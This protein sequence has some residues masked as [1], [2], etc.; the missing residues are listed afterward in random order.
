MRL[1]VGLTHRDWYRFLAQHEE[2]EEV[3]FWRPRSKDELRILKPGDPFLFKLHY[4]K[5]AIC[6][7]GWFEGFTRLPVLLAWK[8]FGEGN[9]AAT[10]DEF[11]K[12]LR[13]LRHGQPILES[14]ELGCVMLHSLVMFPREDWIQEPPDWE[15]NIVQGKGYEAE[16]G[17]GRQLWEQV[18]ERLPGAFLPA[19]EHREEAAV[20]FTESWSR[21]RLGQGAF[22]AYVANAYQRRC[23]FTRERVIPTLETCH[24]RP[25]ARGGSHAVSNGLLLRSDVHQLF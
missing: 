10:Y 5:R 16:V 9:G 15:P 13:S 14:E 1:Y 6:G 23:A 24:I 21:H 22:A 11:L 4:P 7:M 3:N 18:L 20:P 19:G 12:R 25:A 8:S 2:L 17:V